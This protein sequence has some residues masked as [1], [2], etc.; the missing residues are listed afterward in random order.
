MDVSHRGPPQAPQPPQTRQRSHR[1][2][3]ASRLALSTLVALTLVSSGCQSAMSSPTPQSAGHHRVVPNEFPL[4]FDG[5]NFQA[6]CYNASGCSVFYHG[7]YQV[8]DAPGE[9]S[10]P[11]KG[12]DYRKSWGSVEIA[13]P[14]FPSPAIVKWTSLDGVAREAAV[15]IG[16]IF[17]DRKVLHQVPESDIP[18][19]SAHD[20]HPDIYLEVNDRTINVYMKAHIATKTLQEPGNRYSDFRADLILAW[21]KTY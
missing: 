8:K 9:V 3:G 19:G 14:N 20:L 12:P 11:P 13:I 1:R 4:R 16:D 15:D 2:H 17:K 21:T 18:E 6:V 7:R 10:G 5:H